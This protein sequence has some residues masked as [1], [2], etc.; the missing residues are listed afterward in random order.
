M[1]LRIKEFS[2]LF[3]K[4]KHK[5]LIFIVFRIKYQFVLQAVCPEIN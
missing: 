1:M 2:K 4:F 3:F 5:R